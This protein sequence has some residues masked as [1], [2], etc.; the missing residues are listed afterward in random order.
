MID[1]KL[2]CLCKYNVAI[3]NDI[4]EGIFLVLMFY[5]VRK[6]GWKTVYLFSQLY[7]QRQRKNEN[8]QGSNNKYLHV[9][10]L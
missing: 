10:G 8:C 5:V 9:T 4:F 3:T 1:N 6:S 2:C 7:I